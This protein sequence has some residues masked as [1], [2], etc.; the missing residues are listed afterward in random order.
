MSSLSCILEA[1][2]WI[3]TE[4]C[5]GL[6]QSVQLWFTGPRSHCLHPQQ[7]GEWPAGHV[8]EPA[9]PFSQCGLK[10]CPDMQA[11]HTVH[12][13]NCQSSD[14]MARVIT[15]TSSADITDSCSP[16][17]SKHSSLDV[18]SKGP[19]W[20]DGSNK[21]QGQVGWLM[22]CL[23]CHQASAPSATAQTAHHI[24]PAASSNM[25][26]G[27]SPHQQPWSPYLPDILQRATVKPAAS[28]AASRHIQSNLAA[29]HQQDT[30]PGPADVM[31]SPADQ[32]AADAAPESCEPVN[33]DA[34]IGTA[35]PVSSTTADPQSDAASIGQ[36]SQAALLSQQ[37]EGMP[38]QLASPSVQSINASDVTG[39]AE[40]GDSSSERHAAEGPQAAAADGAAAEKFHPISAIP[41]DSSAFQ[42]NEGMNPLAAALA[43]AFLETAPKMPRAGS[44]ATSQ[45][46]SACTDAADPLQHASDL[47][48]ASDREEAC[49][50]DA[51]GMAHVLPAAA[52]HGTEERTT[53][54]PLSSQNP[55]GVPSSELACEEGSS[56]RHL[57][58]PS[59]APMRPEAGLLSSPVVSLRWS[60]QKA[61]SARA[62][63]DQAGQSSDSQIDA[64]GTEPPATQPPASEP[65]QQANSAHQIQ[66]LQCQPAGHAPAAAKP[67]SACPKLFDALT[68]QDLRGGQASAAATLA[69]AQLNASEPQGHRPNGAGSASAASRPPTAQRNSTEDAT[70]L[71]SGA[72]SAPPGH[73]QAAAQA[74]P[75]KAPEK[76]PALDSLDAYLEGAA[77]MPS[78]PGC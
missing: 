36:G 19:F 70:P 63:T 64:A 71:S 31:L 52:D 4:L 60:Q 51:S 7:Q 5:A 50:M 77:L 23:D 16:A 25:L 65:V 67:A 35:Q 34:T 18:P 68:L 21:L 38:R 47:G 14:Q 28:T 59:P 26:P 49:A 39:D 42:L 73:L 13:F 15:S 32:A 76:G 17:G 58:S 37:V 66:G 29:Q 1:L 9:Q 41:A 75:A 24:L 57:A 53:L 22:E 54:S 45:P 72:G 6:D 48:S 74:R 27:H 62:V 10:L 78:I 40:P 43:A 56:S 46:T 20:N 61:P 3:G 12:W 2:S 8:L 69:A 33:R 55:A 30:S 44:A 11:E